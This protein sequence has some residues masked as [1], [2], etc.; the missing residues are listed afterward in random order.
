MITFHLTADQAKDFLQ[1]LLELRETPIR[2]HV[3]EQLRLGLAQQEAVPAF[4]DRD[5]DEAQRLMHLRGPLE[6]GTCS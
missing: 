3:A 5:V 4:T 1:D 2:R 6:E